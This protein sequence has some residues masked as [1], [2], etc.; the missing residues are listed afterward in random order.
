MSNLFKTAFL[1]VLHEQPEA[2]ISDSEAMRQTLDQ[3]TDPSAFDSDAVAAADHALAAS[4]MHQNM[5]L[6]LSGWIGKLEDF[7]EFLNG[8]GD[9]SM[10]TK[11]KNSPP[12]TLYDKIRISETKK[13]ARVS[14]EITSLSEMLKGYLASSSSTKLAGV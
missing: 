14:M 7:S 8:T 12:E 6:G 11:L 5:V 3:G 4:K 10:Q 13:I 2:E 1:H 9:G